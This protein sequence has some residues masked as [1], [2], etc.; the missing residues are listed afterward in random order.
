MIRLRHAASLL[1]L[2]AVAACG[3]PTEFSLDGPLSIRT[4]DGTLRLQNRTAGT[5][6]TFVIEREDAALVDWIPCSDPL[7]CEGLAP[8]VERSIPYDEISGY[9]RGDREAI[10]YWWVLRAKAGGGFEAAEIRNEIVR[11]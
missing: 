2:A 10:V 5:V 3:G 1:A 6:F 4:D 8:N 7:A 11:L 9:D